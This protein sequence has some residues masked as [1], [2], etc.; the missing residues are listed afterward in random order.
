MKKILVP[1]DFS[2]FAHNA[3]EVAADLALKTNAEIILLHANEKMVTATPM[4]EYYLYDKAIEDEYLDMVTES[5]KKTLV[6]I[7]DN[8]KFARVK[9]QTAVIGGPMV[10]VI[11]D[12]VK[13]HAID[14]VVM[15]T[16][17][18]SGMEEFIVGSNT[19]KVIRRVKCPV[20]AIPNLPSSFNKIVFPTTLKADQ[21]PAFAAFAELQNIFKGEVSLLYINDPGHF[22]NTEA[23]EAQ[24]EFLVKESGLKNA[25]LFI[26]DTEVFNEEDAILDFAYQNKADLIVMG[27]HQRRGLAHLFMGSMT[28]DTVNHSDIPVLSLSIK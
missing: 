13:D 12:F 2:G 18:V 17:G 14:L 9:I 6:E 20:L 21:I 1:T 27:T 15:G 24:K 3:L 23:M 16:R 8:G 22:K 4:A 19:E 10:G 28:E 25:A 26:S 11:E 5:L 7:A